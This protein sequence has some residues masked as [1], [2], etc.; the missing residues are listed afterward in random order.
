MGWAR[1]WAAQGAGCRMLCTHVF[2]T[3]GAAQDAQEAANHRP[4]SLQPCTHTAPLAC[5]LM[6]WC[7]PSWA[8]SV[9]SRRSA[10]PSSAHA[11]RPSITPAPRRLVCMCRVCRG[12]SGVQPACRGRG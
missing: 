12:G 3:Q 9:A 1:G 6:A 10:R 8:R 2:I 4:T 7:A 11:P 5:T